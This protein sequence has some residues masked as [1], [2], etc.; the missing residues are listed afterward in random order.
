MRGGR[1]AYVREEKGMQGNKER[2]SV[3]V[4]NVMCRDAGIGIGNVRLRKVS[5]GREQ[6]IAVAGVLNV[7]C[8]C[9]GPIVG[10]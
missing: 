9:W 10:S 4:Q 3:G 7:P 1:G 8:A 2:L 5:H 6:V